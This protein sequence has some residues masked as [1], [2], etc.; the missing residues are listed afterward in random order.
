MNSPIFYEIGLF[1]CY[2]KPK[3][4]V[5]FLIL[6]MKTIMTVRMK[7]DGLHKGD[8]DHYGV[9]KKGRWSS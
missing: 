8:E 2:G 9:S 7:G 4:G 5:N 1:F 3:Q 6:E